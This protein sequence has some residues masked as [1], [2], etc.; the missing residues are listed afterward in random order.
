MTKELLGKKGVNNPTLI[1]SNPNL[2]EPIGDGYTCKCD[3]T[4]AHGAG[5]PRMDM[6]FSDCQKITLYNSSIQG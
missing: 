4:R 5:E 2:Q 3:V 1:T 6:P